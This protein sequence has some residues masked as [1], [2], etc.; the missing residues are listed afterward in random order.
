MNK[1]LSFIDAKCPQN[2]YKSI[3]S[4]IEKIERQFEI[5]QTNKFKNLKLKEQFRLLL[6]MLQSP[7]TNVNIEKTTD[8]INTILRYFRNVANDN[9]SV[10]EADIKKLCIKIGSFMTNFKIREKREKL[11]LLKKKNLN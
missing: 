9:L 4:D 3:I 6:S 7:N 2:I 5:M 8:Q 10:L 11:M 1:I